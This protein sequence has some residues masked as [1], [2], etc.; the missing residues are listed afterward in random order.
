VLRQEARVAEGLDRSRQVP[1]AVEV[2]DD[3][4]S[5]LPAESAA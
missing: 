1:R 2:L 3:V 4:I 5:S